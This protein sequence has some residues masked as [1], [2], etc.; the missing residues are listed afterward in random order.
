ML[1]FFAQL[2]AALPLRLVHALG[3]A[4]GWL[5]Y[6]LSGRYRSR[7]RAHLLTAGYADARMRRAAIAE[8]GKQALEAVW[9]WLRPPE[10]LLAKISAVDFDQLKALQRAGRPTVYLSPHLGCFEILSKGYAL[11][12]HPDTRPFTALYRPARY[13]AL[14][15]LMQTGRRLPGLHLAPASVAGVRQLMRALK[16]GHVTG[17]LPD[18]VP[19]SGEGVWAPFFGQWAYT[20]TLPARLAR[21][22]DANLVFYVGERLPLGRGWRLH[23]APVTEPLT[24]DA[25]TD[26]TTLNRAAEALIR[27]MPAQYLWGYHRY[28]VPAGAPLPPEESASHIPSP[29]RGGLGWGW[30]TQPSNSQTATAHRAPHPHPYPPLEGEGVKHQPPHRAKERP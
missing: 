29:S 8:A 24:G 4:G 18:Q 17:V 20:M 23:I 16:L 21:A 1:H 10:D 2:I 30:G 5:A 3:A 12:A 26:A 7:L 6:A 19:S 28:K 9:V 14:E 15:A 13:R 11:H 27:K 22:C 25:L